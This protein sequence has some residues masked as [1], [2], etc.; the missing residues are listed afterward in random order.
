MREYRAAG[1]AISGP[2]LALQPQLIKLAPFDGA[3][4]WLLRAVEPCVQ[5]Q[6]SSREIARLEVI[7]GAEAV[8]DCTAQAIGHDFLE[9]APLAAQPLTEGPIV[10]HHIL[11]ERAA[12]ELDG[13]AISGQLLAGR[14]EVSDINREA[15][16]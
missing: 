3:E 6:Q 16:G 15:V 11:Q 10:G 7:A 9:K 4:Q 14:A 13:T 12:E 1:P 5:A 2:R 8:D